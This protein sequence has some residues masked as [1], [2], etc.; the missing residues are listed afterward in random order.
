MFRQRVERIVDCRK[1]QF[2]AG[3]LQSVEQCIGG[4]VIFAHA[5]EKVDYRAPLLGRAYSSTLMQ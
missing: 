2:V 4:D 3:V 1:G 5:V